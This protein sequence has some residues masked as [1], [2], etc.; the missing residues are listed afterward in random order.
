MPRVRQ[1]RNTA[2]ARQLRRQMSL[3]EV[4][5]WQ[6]MR[7]QSEFKFRRQHPLGAYVLDFYCPAAKLCVEIDGIAHEMGGNPAR[8]A[9]RDEWLREQGAEVL[10]IPASEVLRSPTNAAETI[11]CHYRG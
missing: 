11:L 10:R 3:P 5:L 9:T 7:Q 4:L 6:E 8:D 2:R 1:P